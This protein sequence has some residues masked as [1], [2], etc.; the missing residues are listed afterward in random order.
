M[1]LS[2]SLGSSSLGI[3][4]IFNM[5]LIK[6]LGFSLLCIFV[7]FALNTR[8]GSIPPLGKV[9]DPFNGIWQNGEP[10]PIK[11]FE[12]KL[13]NLKKAVT[14]KFDENIVPYIKAQNN[15]DAYFSIG[16]ISAFHR[17]WKMDFATRATEGR[18]SEI[19]GYNEK[20]LSHD[21]LQRQKGIKKIA[22]LA[23]KSVM[24]NP[25]SSE[26]LNAFCD[27]INAFIFSLKYKNLPIEFKILHYK[28]EFW[29]PYKTM[30]LIVAM[31]DKLSGKDTALAY[32]NALRLFRRE[33]FDFLYPDIPRGTAPIIKSK[34][35]NF[36]PL[37]I[38]KPVG[39]AD[40]LPDPVPYVN[41]PNP[42]YNKQCK[43]GGSN[44][45]ILSGKKTV[46]G[47][48]FLA[49]D[50]HLD[51]NLPSL[52]YLMRVETPSLNICGSIIP[53]I[54]GFVFGFNKNL[55]WGI[56]N[57]L[58]NCR[59]WYLIKFEDGSFREYRYDNKILKSEIT[60]E[61][62][63]IR[64]RN[65]VNFKTVVTHLGPVFFPD[66]DN[67]NFYGYAM[68][69][70]TAKLGNVIS[71]FLYINKAKNRHEF[72]KGIKILNLNL[73]VSMAS[74]IDEDIAIYVA[75]R[76]IAY[77]KEQGKFIMNGNISDF[78]WQSRIPAE[79]NPKIINP[80]E[81]YLRSANDRPVYKE[82]PYYLHGYWFWHFRNKR[83]D[84]LL[85][86]KNK[87]TITDMKN[88]QQDTYDI[89]ASMLLPKILKYIE[90]E[91]LNKIELK[92]F[93]KLQN[94]D[95]DNVWN[96]EEPSLYR[97]WRRMIFLYL[98]KGIINNK[99]KMRAPNMYHTIHIIRHN[100]TSKYL[101]F[102][103]YGSMKGLVCAA[104]HKAIVNLEYWKIKNN[105]PYIWGNFNKITLNH[106]IP[107]FKSFGIHDIKIGGSKDSI[108]YNEPGTG[109]SGRFI[110]ELAKDKIT[111]LFIYPGGQSGSP[112]N[113]YYDRF[114]KKWENGEYIKLQITKNSNTSISFPYKISLIPR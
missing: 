74:S 102:G 29:S 93:H 10:D 108:N 7:T 77:W 40:K 59:D 50:P 63:N 99:V 15:Y 110:C 11:S 6:L 58:I 98:W 14:I 65:S 113:V 85:N 23:L 100:P 112:L 75:G 109:V 105:K 37:N 90:K 1:I 114:V 48:I 103:N 104:F 18:L 26:C 60:I 3:N 36:K 45:W 52:F 12:I 71:A 22:L 30:L 62:I 92:L 46:S 25:E 2:A 81:N 17:L 47:N 41:L 96:R 64:N 107:I 88:M 97:E 4:M 57:S 106:V 13:K 5:K 83:I 67:K 78:E 72:E 39:I 31:A 21:K 82:Y 94:W 8:I 34:N 35:W 89:S 101:D 27:G 55:A 42:K 38:K 66:S 53:G 54:P 51:I 56:T 16:Y 87:F 44:S 111:G 33:K 79:H 28:P 19:F 49:N 80:A 20:I 32:T 24:S 70:S 86:S 43:S 91:K 69:W 84:Y 73:N 61:K 9:L 76:Y 95:Y 68:K